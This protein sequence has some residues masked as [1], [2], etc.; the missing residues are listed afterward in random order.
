MTGCLLLLSACGSPQMHTQTVPNETYRAAL[1]RTDPDKFDLPAHG[2][3][4]EAAMKERLLGLFTNY[5]AE[6]LTENVSKVYA[7]EVYFRDAFHVM[8]DPVEIRDYFVR[9]LEA[10]EACEFE[11]AE[12]AR[13][14][15]DFYIRWNMRLKFKKAKDDEWEESL[16]MSHF[17]FN[18]QGQVIFH[19]DYWDPT[20]IVYRRI[21][22]ANRLIAYV[23]KKF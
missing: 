5:N 14:G 23:K 7:D 10:L 22:I 18:S 11:F 20:D 19:Q 16:G 9:S 17:R 15:G 21:P 1:E 3:A 6:Y 12:V 2:S 13:E 4:E 8:S